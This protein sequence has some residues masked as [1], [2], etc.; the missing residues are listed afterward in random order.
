MTADTLP[1]ASAAAA[2]PAASS[3][4]RRDNMQ[5]NRRRYSAPEL[6]LRSAPHRAGFRYRCDFRIDLRGGQVRPDI[7]FTRRRVAIF[8]DR[9]FGRCYPEHDS[10]P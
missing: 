9:C 6:A 10:K 1:A 3:E 2:V 8:V 5:A 7:V 4:G